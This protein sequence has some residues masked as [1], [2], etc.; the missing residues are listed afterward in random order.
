MR[1]GTCTGWAFGL[2]LYAGTAL[3]GMPSVD[4]RDLR[5]RHRFHVIPVQGLSMDD[6]NAIAAGVEAQPPATVASP[7]A[8]AG[9]AQPEAAPA[10]V[11]FNPG[12]VSGGFDAGVPASKLPL[13]APPPTTAAP[14]AISPTVEKMLGH[15]QPEPPPPPPGADLKMPDLELMPV[16]GEA[17]SAVTAP[18]STGQQTIRPAVAPT[19]AT[20]QR[21]AD[22]P[23]AAP[24]KAK[25]IPQKGDTKAQKAPPKDTVKKASK[26]SG[27]DEDAPRGVPDLVMAPE[28]PAQFDPTQAAMDGV[29]LTPEQIEAATGA[30]NVTMQPV[31]I[32]P[33]PT[34]TGVK[35]GKSPEVA[36]PATP[37]PR[38]KLKNMVTSDDESRARAAVPM[39]EPVDSQDAKDRRMH[40]KHKKKRKAKKAAAIMTQ[41]CSPPDLRLETISS[42]AAD[43]YRLRGVLATPTEGYHYDVEPAAQRSSFIAPE[44]GPALMSMTLAMKRPT[45]DYHPANGKVNIDSEIQVAPATKRIDVVVNNV[46]GRRAT[47]YYCRIPGSLD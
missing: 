39:A 29:V 43:R 46:L 47:V 18:V 13:S 30:K 37:A 44:G 41:P 3:A 33:A 34:Q 7:P 17:P 14:T 12:N 28:V 24:D 10:V 19:A 23:I 20:S 32:T 2:A 9:G 22:A 16:E 27:H 45:G 35:M 26:A 15:Q 4:G 42:G 21:A 40:H 25:E 11:P 8:G 31:R 1:L 38:G 5:D 36:A 6:L